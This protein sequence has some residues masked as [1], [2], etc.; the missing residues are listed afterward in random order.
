MYFNY[1]HF[2]YCG[3]FNFLYSLCMIILPMPP[4]PVWLVVQDR[5]KYE[6]ELVVKLTNEGQPY[7]ATV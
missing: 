3:Y 7:V 5:Y 4:N 2:Y 6:S 1:T